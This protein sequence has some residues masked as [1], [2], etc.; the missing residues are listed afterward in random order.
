MGHRHI[1]FPIGRRSPR[2]LLPAA[3]VGD[4]NF[5]FGILGI[6]DVDRCVFPGGQVQTHRVGRA[7][8]SSKPETV[9]VVFRADCALIGRAEAD[10][11]ATMIVLIF[12]SVLK[13][14]I[15]LDGDGVDSDK[16]GGP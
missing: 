6:L 12:V 9:Q 15:G 2:D 7:L 5:A 14:G 8:I 16:I 13:C 1:K 10:R 11:S 4:Q 3:A